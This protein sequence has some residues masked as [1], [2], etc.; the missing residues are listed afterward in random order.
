MAEIVSCFTNIG[1]GAV[2]VFVVCLCVFVHFCM[3]VRYSSEFGSM[4]YVL[5]VCE[6]C[7]CL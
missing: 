6:E 3:S 4:Y 7:E 5:C 2:L 1:K